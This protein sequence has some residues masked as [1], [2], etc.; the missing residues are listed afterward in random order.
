[1]FCENLYEAHQQGIA[2]RAID[3]SGVYLS[4]EQLYLSSWE[5]SVNQK[6]L[7]QSAHI[8]ITPDKS[9]WVDF[10]LKDRPILTIEDWINADL[11]STGVFTFWLMT[12]GLPSLY[13][14]EQQKQLEQAGYHEQHTLSIAC[15]KMLGPV[16]ERPSSLAEFYQLAFQTSLAYL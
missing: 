9:P 15:L 13:Q 12:G 11:Y 8:K 14:G 3:L 2:H 5:W 4:D 7:Q 16:K 10:E 1:M 6:L